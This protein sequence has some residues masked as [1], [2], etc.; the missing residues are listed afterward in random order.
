MT[1][2]AVSHQISELERELD[3]KLFIR[4]HHHVEL[5]TAG[6][7]F[8]VHARQILASTRQAKSRVYDVTHGKAG[9]L[10]VLTVQNALETT[11][12][13]LSE[14][15][16]V[17]PDVRIEADVV[18]G[19]EQMNAIIHDTA[20]IY[21]SFASLLASYPQMD[22]RTLRKT[23]YAVM[24]PAGSRTDIDTSDLSRF[25]STPLI[26]ERASEAPFLVNEIMRICESRGLVPQNIHWCNSAISQILAVK[27]GL[28]FSI[29]ASSQTGAFT[30]DLTIIPINS[31]D[32]VSDDTLGWKRSTGNQAVAYFLEVAKRLY[33]KTVVD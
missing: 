20:D 9:H 4:S 19:A 3:T 6:K 24:L 21:I 29:C 22:C 30:D 7:E 26:C 16:A 27:S 31:P 18:T 32:A 23:H 17:C 10:R 11:V 8:L 2:P 1:Q 33:P 12:K 25:S 28:G 14:F 13:L 15:S 5:T